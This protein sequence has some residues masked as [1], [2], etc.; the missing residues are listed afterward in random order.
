MT[1]HQLPDAHL[2]ELVQHIAERTLG[3][4]P[5]H[6]THFNG[7]TLQHLAAHGQLNAFVL[8]QIFQEWNLHASKIHHAYFDFKHPEVRQALQGFQNILSRHIRVSRAD[9]RVLLEKAAFNNLKLLLQPY[10]TLTSFFFLNKDVLPL[11]AYEKYTGYFSD[12]DFVVVSILTHYKK[13]NAEKI[14]RADFEEQAKKV[15]SLYN[16][17]HTTDIETYRDTQFT[18]LTGQSLVSFLASIPAPAKAT[19]Q[20]VT[21]P[22]PIQQTTDYFDL[23]ARQENASRTSKEEPGTP[24]PSSNQPGNRS[25]GTGGRLVDQFQQHGG[26]KLYEKL[27]NQKRGIESVPIHL[28]FQVLQKI[29]NGNNVLFLD[30]I[31]NLN[32][33][34]SNE[35]REAYLRSRIFPNSALPSDDPL[36][37]QFIKLFS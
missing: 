5:P 35:E 24:P 25:S 20:P 2:R 15:I 13:K 9:Y 1:P 32:K 26:Q 12:F 18:S 29:F 22:I 23:L 11:A 21:P 33:L 28:R 36:F 17:R 6:E 7:D 37:D 4:R 10:E 14:H 19:P 16:E 3:T 34:G 30:T 8:F 31:E 27:G